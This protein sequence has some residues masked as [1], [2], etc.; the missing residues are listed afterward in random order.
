VG[1]LLSNA[2]R[3][4]RAGGVV[5]CRVS[6]EGGRATLVV[7]DYGRGIGVEFLPHVFEPFSSEYGCGGSGLGLAVV[8]HVIREHGGSVRAESAGRE[9]GA[10]FIVILPCIAVAQV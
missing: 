10:T 3:F 4:S 7:R 6:E 5:D 9:Q 8:Q 1:N 2:I